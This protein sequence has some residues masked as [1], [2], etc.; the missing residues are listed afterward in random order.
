MNL[1]SS[2]QVPLISKVPPGQSHLCPPSRFMQII[3]AVQIAVP[4]RA[5]CTHSFISAK[6]E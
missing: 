5:A 2:T 4:L 6:V 3:D 1:P